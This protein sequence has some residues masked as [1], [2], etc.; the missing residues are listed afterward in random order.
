MEPPPPMPINERIIP[1]P[2]NET[3]MIAEK[4][5]KNGNQKDN[6]TETKKRRHSGCRREH[7]GRNRE[8][9]QPKSG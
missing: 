5:N 9:N 2:T 6:K 3:E 4:E 8:S 1:M 7:T